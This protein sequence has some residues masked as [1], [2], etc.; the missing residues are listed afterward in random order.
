MAFLIEAIAYLRLSSLFLAAALKII[1]SSV[2]MIPS[3]AFQI[4]ASFDFGMVE[5]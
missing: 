3:L 2:D 1:G 4:E 5:L